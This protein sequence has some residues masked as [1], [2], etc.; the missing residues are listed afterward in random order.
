M[1]SNGRI[2]TT[3]CLVLLQELL[4]QRLSHAMKTLHFEC[5]AGLFGPVEY[6][7]CCLGIVSSKLWVDAVAVTHQFARTGEVADIGVMLCGEHREM[8]Q[9]LLLRKFDFGIPVGTFNQTHHQF[10][11]AL[12]CPSVE[13]IQYRISFAVVSLHNNTQ[14]IPTG[15][16][17]RFNQVANDIERYLK[18]CALFSINIEANI[19]LLSK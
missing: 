5:N 13:L 4:M 11:I 18:A 7:G 9:P 12:I 8:V 3:T 6:T 1:R 14:T 19:V 10:A 15:K 16:L 17:R 2:D